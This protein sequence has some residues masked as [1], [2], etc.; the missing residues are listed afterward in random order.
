MRLSILRLAHM[1]ISYV[2]NQGE[3]KRR[4]LGMQNSCSGFARSRRKSHGIRASDKNGAVVPGAKADQQDGSPRTLEVDFWQRKKSGYI[5][6]SSHH[7]E[8]IIS[9][10]SNVS[11]SVEH[12]IS[13]RH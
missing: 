12:R 6:I 8:R 3:A 4:I 1:A 2:Q 9:V 10:S 13:V 11:T 5:L 7:F